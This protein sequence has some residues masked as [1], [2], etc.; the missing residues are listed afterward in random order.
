MPRILHFADAHIDMTN[1]GQH[2][3]KSGLPLRVMDFLKS[4]DT[5]VNTAIDEKVDLVIFAGDTYRD[6]SPQPTFQREWGRR[7]MR[8]SRAGIPTLL[9]TGN[10]DISPAQIRAHA[11]Q[12]F[13]TLE[14]AFVHVVSR[15]SL[16][17]PED[18]DGVPVQVIALPWITRAGLVASLQGSDQPT[19]DPAKAIEAILTEMVNGA[20]AQ[21]DPDLP[22]ILTAHASVEGAKFGNEQT[23]KVGKDVLLQPRFVSN[24]R[25]D[26]VALGHIHKYQNLNEG[27]YPPVIY[28]GSIER[29]DF[30]EINEDKGFIIADVQKGS[31]TFERRILKTRPF[32]DLHMRLE[33]GDD[34]MARLEGIL[35]GMH[36]V[37]GAI[38]RLRIDYPKE[39]ETQI[40][41]KRLRDEMRG[42]FEFYLAK[43]PS[44]RARARLDVNEGT[45]SMPPMALMELYWKE[46]SVSEAGRTELGRLASQIISDVNGGLDA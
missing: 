41:E 44:T 39:L 5:I 21:L 13:E 23:I 37:D 20:I 3:P 28:P 1:Y 6:R 30:G 8:L 34:V 35:P 12:E 36:V 22:T 46:N 15:P 9:I 7:I 16:L 19:D 11:M 27:S 10:H 32:I 2:D 31:T 25:F 24:P 29:V 18:L 43:N 45:A 26:Y 14:P 40:D 17:T 33:E 38:V 4:L 42:A